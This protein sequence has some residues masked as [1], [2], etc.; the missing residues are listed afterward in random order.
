MRT[1][2]GKY[3]M[4][5]TNDSFVA[6]IGLDT[7]RK[8]TIQR[9]PLKI[10]TTIMNMSNDRNIPK[11]SNITDIGTNNN[12]INQN[13]ISCDPQKLSQFKWY[14]TYE[15]GSHSSRLMIL[16]SIVRSVKMFFIQQTINEH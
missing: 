4:R 10:K 5:S 7:L 2:H 9:N 15:K 13:W 16:S 8:W 12:T 11:N 1:R 3:I 6:A 14:E